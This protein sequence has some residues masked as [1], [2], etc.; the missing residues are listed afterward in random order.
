LAAP[1][2][3]LS[4]AALLHD[5]VASDAHFVMKLLSAAPASNLLPLS[6]CEVSCCVATFC[7]YVWFGGH[8]LERC[9]VLIV[10]LRG[11]CSLHFDEQQRP[12]KPVPAYKPPPGYSPPWG[13]FLRSRAITTTSA[14]VSG[15]PVAG[16]LSTLGASTPRRDVWFLGGPTSALS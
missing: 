2:S 4:A 15:F 6:H 13:L 14:S 8:N 3:F 12:Q 5:A 9:L 11:G 16:P 7:R 10:V 1:E